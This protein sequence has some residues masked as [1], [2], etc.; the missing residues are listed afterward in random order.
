LGYFTKVK[1]GLSPGVPRP[2]GRVVFRK[3]GAGYKRK[4]AGYRTNPKGFGGPT[5]NREAREVTPHT[6]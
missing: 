3:K 6:K 2:P 5:H 1:G 4:G